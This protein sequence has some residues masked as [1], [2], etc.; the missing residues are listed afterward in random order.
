MAQVSSRDSSMKLQSQDNADVKWI[1]SYDI[2]GQTTV[3]R[4][5]NELFAWLCNSDKMIMMIIINVIY[6]PLFQKR[7]RWILYKTQQ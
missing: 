6:I 3:S 5:K 1:L 7:V 4:A 2:F